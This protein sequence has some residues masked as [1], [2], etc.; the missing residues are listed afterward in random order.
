MPFSTNDRL[1]VKCEKFNFRKI[2]GSLVNG[3]LETFRRPP[4]VENLGN[5]HF[6]VQIFNKKT[7]VGFPYLS[8]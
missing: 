1:R 7:V 4:A 5:I 2:L 8:T 6:F 3:H